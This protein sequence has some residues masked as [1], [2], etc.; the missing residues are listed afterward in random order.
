MTDA[1][2][3]PITRTSTLGVLL[4]LFELE[5]R[6]VSVHYHPAQGKGR[7][8]TA[9][10]RGRGV[11]TTCEAKVIYMVMV[12]KC[13]SFWHPTIENVICSV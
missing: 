13:V 6:S 3:V 8:L 2:A 5:R 1:G 11:N 4:S 7:G 9:L 12:K 10:E